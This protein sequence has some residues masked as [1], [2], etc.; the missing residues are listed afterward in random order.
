MKIG[1]TIITGLALINIGV[2]L[3]EFYWVGDQ[4]EGIWHLIIGIGLLI[5]AKLD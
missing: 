4:L 5:L 2:A 3:G 1:F